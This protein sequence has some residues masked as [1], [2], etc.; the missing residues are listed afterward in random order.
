MSDVSR[1][2]AVFGERA[3]LI[4]VAALAF[5]VLNFTLASLMVAGAY[6]FD[7]SLLTSG[8]GLV[9]RGQ[10]A[11]GLLRLGAFVD[12]VG[13]LALAPVTFYLH[14]RITAAMPE[15]LRRL[16]LP[17]T[18]TFGALGFVIVGAIG[19]VTLAA[20]GPWLI[21][22]AAAD[23]AA[24]SVARLQFGALEKFVLVG[25]WGTLELLLLGLWLIGVSWV[26]R[27][28]GRAFAWLGVVCGAGALG[29][30]VRSGLTG[31]T[32]IALQGP[33][34]VLTFAALGLLP[35]WVIWLSF[36]LWRGR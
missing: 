20:V 16:G 5:L 22:A 25:L 31:Q 7:P 3:P 2:S 28:E 18:L 30:S 34:D 32:P 23:P 9:E 17:W 11:A 27:A 14:G 35:L 8:G 1:G 10:S 19:A 21:E 33:T 6:D 24:Q 36:R 26:V 12:M 29:Y 13:Y 15:H 4:A